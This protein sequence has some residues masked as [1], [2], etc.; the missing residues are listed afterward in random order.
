MPPL[1]PP[2][3]LT[4]NAMFL[5]TKVWH[6]CWE[7]QI[8]RRDIKSH[9]VEP[10]LTDTSMVRKS[11]YYGQFIW[12]LR[13]RNPYK[14]YFPKTDT[15]IIRTFIPGPLMSVITRFD[16]TYNEGVGGTDTVESMIKWCKLLVNGLV[17]Q[18]IH[19]KIHIFW[20]KKRKEEK[21][22]T[23][24]HCKTFFGQGWVTFW[25]KISNKVKVE[26]ISYTLH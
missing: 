12:S 2:P 6:F 24:V 18:I 5:A 13:D 20:K 25:M 19:V 11:L 9:T 14:A 26:L 16:C 7:Q 15:S 21:K 17:Q 4:L 23:T 1:P 3:P 22:L 10:L 8:Q